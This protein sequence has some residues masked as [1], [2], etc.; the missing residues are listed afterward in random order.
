MKKL[1]LVAAP[2]A[3]G[4]NYVS[5]LLCNRLKS[6]AYMDKDDLAGL[7]R[8]CF[9]HSGEKLDMDGDFYLKNLRPAEYE[10]LM[11]MAFSALR[12]E[13]SVVVNAP[14]LKEV[15]DALYMRKLKAQ[16]AAMG[17][18][19]ILI[20]VTAPAEACYER[21]KQRNSDRDSLKLLDWKAYLQTI[22][23][24]VPNELV[25]ANG[26]DQLFVFDNTNAE[27]GQESLRYILEK[28]GE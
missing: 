24:S 27:T 5:E 13:K 17:A 3:C 7:L 28:L 11:R 22:D 16:A 14:F 21:M 15:R 9:T 25:E 10:T 1:I 4:K 2:P 8:C 26:V 20:W 23:F 19:L 12:F 18:Q 6:V